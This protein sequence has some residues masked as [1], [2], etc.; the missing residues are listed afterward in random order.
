MSSVIGRIGPRL[1][2]TREIFTPGK[3]EYAVLVDVM[4]IFPLY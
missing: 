3:F 4:S 1:K 2:K